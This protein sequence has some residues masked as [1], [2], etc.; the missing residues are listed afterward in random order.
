MYL[1][2]FYGLSGPSKNRSALKSRPTWIASYIELS[3]MSVF[4]I[5]K[6]MMALS[7]EA[8]GGR[9][10]SMIL[11]AQCMHFALPEDDGSGPGSFRLYEI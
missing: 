11:E 2:T 4:H 9:F 3:S 7:T 1:M 8:E 6:M 5:V 10:I